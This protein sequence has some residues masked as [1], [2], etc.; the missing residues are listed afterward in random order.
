[1]ELQRYEEALGAARGFVQLAPRDAWAR[2]LEGLA[3]LGMQ[4]FV[5]AEAPLRKSFDLSSD[6][7]LRAGALRGLERSLAAQG[8]ADEAAECRRRLDELR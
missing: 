4:R 3:L 6:A 5:E 7:R 1:M 2:Q 8:R